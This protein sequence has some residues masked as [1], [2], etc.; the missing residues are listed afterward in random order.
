MFRIGGGDC[1]G[2]EVEARAPHIA[3]AGCVDRR[4][5][6]ASAAVHAP[7]HVVGVDADEVADLFAQQT[8]DAS[9]VWDDI[10]AIREAWKGKLLIKGIM[11]PEDARIATRMGVDGILVS[12]H[13]G[14]QLDNMPSPVEM[15]PMIRPSCR[16]DTSSSF[17]PMCPTSREPRGHSADMLSRIQGAQQ[18]P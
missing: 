15:L 18:I 2:R 7:H 8:P 9:Q 17:M 11:H 4:A 6:L 5:Q 1:V 3:A 16:A 13:G 10:A 14:R 12:N